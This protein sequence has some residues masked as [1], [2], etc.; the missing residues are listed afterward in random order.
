MGAEVQ[1]IKQMLRVL[2]SMAEGKAGLRKRRHV[3]STCIS[4]S[5]VY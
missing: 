3:G 2:S 5:I 4:T 1:V